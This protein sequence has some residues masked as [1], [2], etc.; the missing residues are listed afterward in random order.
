MFIQYF[1]LV[2]KILTSTPTL[3]GGG[4][5]AFTFIQSLRG[6]LEIKTLKKCVWFAVVFFG[7]LAVIEVV[8][9]YF[10]YKS[11]PMGQ[12]FIPPYQP[13]HWFLLYSWAHFLAPFVFALASG[14]FMY[15]VALS[16]N[17]SFQRELF[18]ENDKYIF[19]LAAIVLS[20]PNY[21]LYLPIAALLVV[22][23]IFLTALVKK[24]FGE[25][26]ILS[27]ALFFAILVTMVSSTT[28]AKYIA[29]WK[30]TI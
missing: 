26:V 15:F 2:N 11:D 14:L 21:I 24:D 5:I 13:I 23:E 20:W 12:L 4:L 28:I 16:T 9:Q 27:N 6:K 3:V 18:V 7:L 30:L 22:L 10:A 29:L 19:L 8:F 1:D 17:N 25:R